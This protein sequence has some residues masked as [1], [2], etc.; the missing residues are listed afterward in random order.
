MRTKTVKLT[1]KYCDGEF[2]IQKNDISKVTYKVNTKVAFYHN[3]NDIVK[4]N[5]PYSQYY[6]EINPSKSTMN[7][8]KKCL[9]T[10]MDQE[11]R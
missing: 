8:I 4:S 3:E 1:G 6:T 9:K 11:R 10:D 2:K 7:K 5:L